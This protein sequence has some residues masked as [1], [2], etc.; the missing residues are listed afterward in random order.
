MGISEPSGEAVLALLAS[1][2]DGSPSS[3][4]G[5]D[6]RHHQ[7]FRLI[8]VTEFTGSTSDPLDLSDTLLHTVAE[9]AHCDHLLIGGS[10]RQR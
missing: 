5:W 6:V 8:A 4:L 2:V 1:V 9:L 10:T 3:L 7:D